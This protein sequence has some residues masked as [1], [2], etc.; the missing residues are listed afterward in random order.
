MQH[1]LII[2]HNAGSPLHGP[3]FRSYYSAL[4]WV[5]NN[6]KATIVCSSFSH[7]LR[8]LPQVDGEYAIEM[9]DGIRYIWIRTKPF[10]NNV[11]RLLNYLQFNR[12]LNLLHRIIK[13]PLDYLICSSPPPFW[14]WF[15]KRFA[16]LKGASLLFEARDLWPDVIF[17]TTRFGFVNPAAWCMKVAE[18]T[19]YKHADCVVSVNESAI[20]I[21]E[22]RRL[23]PSRFCAIPNGTAIETKVQKNIAPD[24][25]IFCNKLKEQGLFVVG[26][27]GALSKIYGLSYL[28]KAAEVLQNE[29]IAFVLAGAGDYEEQLRKLAKKLPNFHLAGWVP[30]D[31]LQS[32]LRSVDICFAGLL[33]VRSF[34][35]GSDSTKIYEYMKASKPVLHAIGNEESVVVKAKCGIRVAPEDS[36]ALV[37]GIRDLAARGTEKLKVMGM[38][39]RDYLTKNRGYD[40]LT[41]K[42]LHLFKS[43]DEIKKSR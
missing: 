43:L 3:N 15:C 12:Q 42:W 25:A 33:N 37:N 4:G 40:I 39:G 26:Y 1:A 27:S 16:S 19:A 2:N 32:F 18:K 11:G 41:Q 23:S 6:M 28:V 22:K 9:I 36:N 10:S 38:Q 8:K 34:A 13:E 21:M 30:K 14:I 24:S 35:Y 5:K 7:K 31:Q 20:K 29:R 17:E